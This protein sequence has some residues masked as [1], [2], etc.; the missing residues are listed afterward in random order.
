[1]PLL[2][3]FD[4][5]WLLLV[6][7]FIYFGLMFGCTWRIHQ[8]GVALSG[9]LIL[10]ADLRPGAAS[11]GIDAAALETL[12]NKE[13]IAVNQD[14]KAAPLVPVF[15]GNG[16]EAWQKPLSDG[17]ALVLFNRNTTQGS[18]AH[19]TAVIAVTWAQLGTCQSC[20]VYTS[21]RPWFRAGPS[22]LRPTR[23][24][25]CTM[26]LPHMYIEPEPPPAPLNTHNSEHLNKNKTGRLPS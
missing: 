4:F 7:S 3:I 26:L 8:H 5:W 12:T 21:P 23:Q 9:P 18:T 11:G 22:H 2:V 17:T 20:S 1:M 24:G 10:S 15:R 16:P 14:P 6:C 19:Q 13:V 25:G